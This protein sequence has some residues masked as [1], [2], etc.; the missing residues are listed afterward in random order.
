MKEIVDKSGF[1][2]QTYFNRLFKRKYGTS[3]LAYRREMKSKD[4]SG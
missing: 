4:I 1:S 2:S 3:P